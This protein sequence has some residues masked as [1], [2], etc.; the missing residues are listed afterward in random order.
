MICTCAIKNYSLQ[1]PTSHR[2]QSVFLSNFGTVFFININ[3]KSKMR[4]DENWL[5][6]FE[7]FVKCNWKFFLLK[8]RKND[9]RKE[10][11]KGK[12]FLAQKSCNIYKLLLKHLLCI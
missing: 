4:S 5:F 6:K 3:I 9:I 7:N 10:V 11:G 8:G 1:L 2:P 12:F